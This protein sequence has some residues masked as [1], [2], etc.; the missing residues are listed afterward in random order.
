MQRYHL[1]HPVYMARHDVPAQFVADLQGS[2]Q[3]QTPARFPVSNIGLGHR[4]RADLNFVPIRP[5]IYDGQADPVA[6]DGRPHVDSVGIVPG[7]DTRPQIA[8]L[9]QQS[10]LA[11]VRNN[12]C[13]HARASSIDPLPK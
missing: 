1:G 10:D 13:K 4:L 2:L 3:V 7:F 6:G 11:N 12:T 9:F 5:K 8:L